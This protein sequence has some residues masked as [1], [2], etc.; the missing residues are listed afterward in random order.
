MWF[1]SLLWFLEIVIL[2]SW[3]KLGLQKAENEHIRIEGKY[4]TA[5][6]LQIWVLLLL[7]LFFQ[8]S[9]QLK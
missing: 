4:Q 8:L 5:I 7:L 2:H 9:T 3:R 1:C 6:S